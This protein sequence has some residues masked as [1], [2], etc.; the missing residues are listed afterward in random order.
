[1]DGV[2]VPSPMAASV[3]EAHAPMSETEAVAEASLCLQCGGPSAPAPCTVA[4]PAGIDI[5]GFVRD[6]ARGVAPEAARKIFRIHDGEVDPVLFANVLNA[7]K[8]CQAS[9]LRDNITYH[10]N[11]HLNK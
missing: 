8:D 2:R 6:I 5:A 9:R 1:M 3:A 11:F 4:C 7:L 10:E